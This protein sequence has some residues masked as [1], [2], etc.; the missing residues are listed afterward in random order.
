MDSGCET[1]GSYGRFSAL[2]WAFLSLPFDDRRSELMYR[3]NS[4]VELSEEQMDRVRRGFFA[5]LWRR[6]FK[7]EFIENHGEEFL[8]KAHLEYV[9]CVVE[10][11]EIED[12]ITWTIHCAWR[13]TQN[14]LEAPKT[15]REVTSE[16]LPELE[17]REAQTTEE[18]AEDLRRAS[19]IR[20]AVSKLRKPEQQIIS[21]TYL[22]D[23][24]LREAARQLDWPLTTAR[25]RFKSA[26]ERLKDLFEEW[27]IE[28]SDDLVID[29]GLASYLASAY[30]SPGILE[31]AFEKIGDVAAIAWEKAHDL[32][33]RV[34]LGGGGDAASV[35]ATSGAG[36][37]AGAC[38]TVVVACVVGAGASG[39]VGP[40]IGGG[41]GLFS[42]H[43][44]SPSGANHARKP[45]ARSASPVESALV[46]KTAAESSTSTTN[47][48]EA[49]ADSPPVAKASSA[50]L[51][52]QHVKRQADFD[53]R[54]QDESAEQEVQPATPDTATSSS[55]QSSS[56]GSSPSSTAKSAAPSGGSETQAAQQFGGP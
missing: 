31:L 47:E 21:L 18:Q 15:S 16:K 48:G 5:V 44:H 53:S 9:R 42:D 33:R 17:D 34:F 56:V 52:R 29:V 8:A 35:A 26:M 27:G 1:G 46:E 40:G 36:R 22:E 45:S 6:R 19:E 50:D 3:L 30:H 37:A 13:R 51:E 12:P 41:V 14:F 54:I 10:G 25:R 55:T 32:P 28:S 38:A 43:H 39:V 23:M 11:V 49:Q 7:P 20:R 2:E 24:T 4:D